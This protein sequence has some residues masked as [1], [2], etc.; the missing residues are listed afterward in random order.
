MNIDSPRA[1]AVKQQEQTI[2]TNLV[3]PGM[4]NG[5]N[6]RGASNKEINQVP[7]AAS[8]QI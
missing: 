7:E 3:S 2:Q 8:N 6:S 4:A 5:S 1:L